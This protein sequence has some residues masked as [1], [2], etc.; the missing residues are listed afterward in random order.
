M[1]EK[2]IT[3]VITS[4]DA[5]AGEAEKISRL[6]DSGVDFVHIRKPDWTLQE[7]RRLIEDIPYSHRIRLRL[8]GHFA[9]LD[10]MNLAGVHI[11]SRCPQAPVN[12]ASV[13]KSCHSTDEL[14]SINGYAYVTLSPIYDSISKSGYESRFDIGEIAPAISGKKVVALGGV[15]PEHIKPLREAG[16]F[17]AALLGYIWKGDFEDKLNHLKEC[18]PSVNSTE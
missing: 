3:I 9:L 7:V 12:A 5:V 17:G 4:P 14:G 8:H 2:F 13:T 6:L 10:E 11:N 15:T 18:M 16:F 1:A